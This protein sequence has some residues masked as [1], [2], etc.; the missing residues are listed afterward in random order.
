MVA[1]EGEL[2]M[3]NVMSPKLEG[4]DDRIQLPVVVGILTFRFAELLIEE[5][6]RVE[7]LR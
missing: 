7:F 1:V 4:L 2:P 3:E 6:Y 5:R